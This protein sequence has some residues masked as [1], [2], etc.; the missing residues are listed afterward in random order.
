MKQ[1]LEQIVDK[2][3]TNALPQVLKKNKQ[4][5]HWMQTETQQHNP[6][7]STEMA[8]IILHGPPPHC[9]CGNRR[10]FNSLHL[11]YRICC[12]L[13][14]KCISSI[15]AK[16][17]G[18]KNHM[19]QH[20]GVANAND[21]P[22]I[23]EKRKQTMLERHGVEYAAQSAAVQ[24]KLSDSLQARTAEQ[25]SQTQQK[26]RA[27]NLERYG[28]ENVT[29]LPE[30]QQKLKNTNIEKYGVEYPLQNA[31]IKQR[32]VQ[33]HA[34]RPEQERKNTQQ[35][36]KQTTYEK[37]GVEHVSQRGKPQWVL[38]ILADADQFNSFVTGKTRQQA[39]T[40]LG[41]HEHCLYLHSKKYQ[42]A[43]LFAKS[44]ISE[45]ERSIGQLLDQWQID[46]IQGERTIIK[47]QE[48]DYYIP[49]KNIAIE[50]SGLY[51]HSEI[52]SNRDK[53]YHINKHTACQNQ[54]IQLITI[55]DDEWTKKSSQVIHRLSHILGQSVT[56]IGARKCTVKSIDFVTARDFVDKW[57]IQGSA[58]ASI[59]L[60][61]YHMD[62][63]L[64]VMTF[65]KPRYN[66]QYSHELVRF[67]TSESVPGAAGRL[68]N[69]FVKTY[70]PSSVISY[71]DNRWGTGNLYQQLGFQLTQT[72]VGYHYTD[73]KNRYN[74]TQ[75]QKHKLV[76]QGHDATLTEW[77]IMQNLGYDRVWDCGQSTWICINNTIK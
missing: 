45:F 73:Y 30:I 67:C 56:T 60:G 68:F 63:L 5:W 57:H 11:G 62:Q 36:T 2:T 19:M 55:F 51:W 26:I 41:I 18:L 8:Y 14:V 28:V 71:C 54:G 70:N 74:R 35:R 49:S 59:N 46:Y 72:T 32:M 7:S 65:S 6:S 16:M 31:E 15:N 53:N 50:C 39:A 69:H 33:T 40:E 61:L 21:V 13:G 3:A 24:K 52:A 22:A 34:S 27:T 20:Y 75:F 38:D 42:S 44:L 1:I 48:L 29:K 47:P 64:A 10:K 9:E 23:A 4:L 12:D 43:S 66:K 77:Q 25:R 58:K 37:Y 17:T 76:E